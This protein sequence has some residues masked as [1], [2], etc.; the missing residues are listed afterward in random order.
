MANVVGGGVSD[1]QLLLSYETVRLTADYSD[2][3]R[4]RTH[5]SIEGSIPKQTHPIRFN[6]VISG[7]VTRSDMIDLVPSD[8]RCEWQFEERFVQ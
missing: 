2:C 1:R 6:P 5:D 4:F 7:N 3:P 8:Q